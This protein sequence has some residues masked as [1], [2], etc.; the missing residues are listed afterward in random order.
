MKR[1]AFMILVTA[2]PA[3]AQLPDKPQ[4]RTA[5]REF[6]IE[7]GAMGTSWTLD[8]VST[9]QL[10]AAHD[11]AHEGGWF[12]Y[13]SRSTPKVMAVWALVDVGAAIG[14]Y[15]WK[16]HVHN[17]YLHPLWRAPMG[18]RTEGHMQAAIGNWRKN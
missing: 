1:I 11:W 18:W 14:A 3:I 6:W 8:T 15:E 12:L 7:A 13:G 9:H 4:P 16:R 5:D 10:F 17:R 2:L